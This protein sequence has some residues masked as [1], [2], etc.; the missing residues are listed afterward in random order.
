MYRQ[1]GAT[2]VKVTPTDVFG[3]ALLCV[4]ATVGAKT[5][6]MFYLGVGDSPAILISYQPAGSGTPTDEAD[7]QRFLDSIAR[8]K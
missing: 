7:W 8:A 6:R 3:I 5:A 1:S 2:D 4:N